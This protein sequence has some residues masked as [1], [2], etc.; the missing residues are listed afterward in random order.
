[1]KV[2]HVI[3]SLHTGGAEKLIIS[4]LPSLVQGKFQVDL[5]LLNGERTPFFEEL[6]KKSNIRI[7][8]L[9][10]S[11]YNPFY[12]FKLIPYLKRYELIHVH[13]FPSMYFVALAK[14]LSF[15]KTT[16]IFTEHST[17]NRRLQSWVFRPLERVIYSMYTAIICISESVK[18]TLQN[19][20]GAADSKY[21]VINNGIQI[22]CINEAV[23]HDRSLFGFGNQDKLMCMV[24][25]F[26]QE[27]DQD[28]VVRSLQLLPQQFKLLFIG[29]GER[30]EAVKQ[31]AIALGVS[32]R[33]TFLGIRT[34]IYS[35][36]KMCDIAILSSHWEGFGLAAAEAMAC[37]IPT[38]AS[39]VNGL[40]QVVSGG[41]LLFEKGNIAELAEQILSLDD[42][43]FYCNIREKGLQRSQNYDLETTVH[44]LINLY[45]TLKY[46]L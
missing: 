43:I 33:V 14:L 17:S 20:M 10:K 32:E 23:A 16:L 44:Q 1:M 29:E 8:F 39:N 41:G 28:T 13:L 45:N 31:L 46:K 26:R 15:S 21:K 42:P 12:I 4:I 34:D 19:K 24:A 11:F 6:Q 30:F 5:L 35:L 37:G 3:N 22:G 9:G 2:L 36:I 18:I 25:A 38:I 27:K 40:A 7:E